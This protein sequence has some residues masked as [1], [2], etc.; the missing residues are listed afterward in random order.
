M[1]TAL[2][3]VNMN[4][5][6]RTIK[7]TRF[8]MLKKKGIGR[9]AQFSQECRSMACDRLRARRYRD[10]I[11]THRRPDRNRHCGGFDV[12]WNE[13]FRDFQ[14]RRAKVVGPVGVNQHPAPEARGRG[15]ANVPVN[16]QVK[17]LPLKRILRKMGL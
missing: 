7:K 16:N 11:W 9:H 2:I 8:W 4:V 6:N 13:P 15:G 3:R 12:D 1:A 14:L 10:R 5:T 17:N